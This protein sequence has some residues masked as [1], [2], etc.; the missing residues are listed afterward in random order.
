MGIHKFYTSTP[1]FVPCSWRVTCHCHHSC[2]WGSHCDIHA[3]S[4]YVTSTQCKNKRLYFYVLQ[5]CSWICLFW[6]PWILIKQYKNN[7][8]N[9]NIFFFFLFGKSYKLS[10]SFLLVS[11]EAY[12]WTIEMC[13][14]THSTCWNTAWDLQVLGCYDYISCYFDRVKISEPREG[15]CFSP[16]L[17]QLG[18]KWVHSEIG[19]AKLR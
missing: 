14:L 7:R 2:L 3:H 10:F 13:C 19:Y 4:I 11:C 16:D 6:D 1:Y 8:N 9:Q 15:S 18:S 5:F 12:T 17:R